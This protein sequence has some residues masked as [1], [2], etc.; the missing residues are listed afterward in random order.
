MKK[1]ITAKAMRFEVKTAIDNALLALVEKYGVEA[2]QTQ[3]VRHILETEATAAIDE[4]GEYGEILSLRRRE[5]WGET[6]TAPA[7]S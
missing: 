6:D 1:T 4:L 3:T 5:G 7:L 2:F